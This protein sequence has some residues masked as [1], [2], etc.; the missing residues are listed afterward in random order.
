M[1]PVAT[2]TTTGGTQ[3]PYPDAEFIATY[4]LVSVEQRSNH[5]IPNFIDRGYSDSQLS[6]ADVEDEL[7]LT[8]AWRDQLPGNW[9]SDVTDK[10]LSRLDDLRRSGDRYVY[11]GGKRPVDAAFV[12]AGLFVRNLAPT[13]SIARTVAD[14]LADHT[15]LTTLE[16][17]CIDRM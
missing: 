5:G 16:L 11:P 4:G 3:H 17:E 8:T 15:T 1:I 10:L 13:M 6:F 9:E 7:E 12:D 2:V 14:V